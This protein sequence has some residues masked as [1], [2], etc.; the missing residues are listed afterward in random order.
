MRERDKR[1]KYVKAGKIGVCDEDTIC[2]EGRVCTYANFT[3]K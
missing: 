2:N 1:K 3:P